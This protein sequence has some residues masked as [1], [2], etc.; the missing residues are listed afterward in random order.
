ME[1]ILETARENVSML[2]GAIIVL[3]L[4]I[5]YVQYYSSSKRKPTKQKNVDKDEID[6]I[7]DSINSQQSK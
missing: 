7:I 3:I 1:F 4:Y 6:G 2:I 5:F